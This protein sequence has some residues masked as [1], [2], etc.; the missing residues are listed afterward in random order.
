MVEHRFGYS[1]LSSFWCLSFF[2]YKTRMQLGELPP[3][4]P[5]KLRQ[6]NWKK[7]A[8]HLADCL[9]FEQKKCALYKGA[10]AFAFETDVGRRR[11]REAGLR[12]SGQPAYFHLRRPTKERNEN[13]RPHR[14]PLSAE[15]ELSAILVLIAVSEVAR[16][17]PPANPRTQSPHLNDG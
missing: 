9:H 7:L 15:S 5:A 12:G 4:H 2:G 1:A 16:W 6:G 17:S 11:L 8:H 13:T 14:L 3:V 10:D